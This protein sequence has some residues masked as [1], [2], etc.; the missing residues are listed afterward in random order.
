MNRYPTRYALLRDR[1]DWPDCTLDGLEADADGRLSRRRVPGL[2]GA[3]VDLPGPYQ[4]APSGVAVAGQFHAVADTGHDV[5]RLFDNSCAAEYVLGSGGPG[6]LAKLAAPAGLAIHGDQLWVADKGHDRLVCFS[7]ATRE[8]I[9]TIDDIA[10]PTSLAVD[11]GGRLHVIESGSGAVRRFDPW[12]AAAEGFD[13]AVL[14][15]AAAPGRIPGPFEPLFLALGSNGILHVS[16][17]SSGKILRFDA[18]GGWLEPFALP[19]GPAGALALADVLYAAD[20]TAGRLTMLDP[21]AG[22]LI[23]TVPGLHAPISGLAAGEAGVLVKTGPDAAI[24]TLTPQAARLPVGTVICG[25]IDAGEEQEWWRA[26]IDADTADGAVTL[27]VWQSDDAGLA[28][29]AWIPAPA[30]STLLAGLADPNLTSRRWIKVRATLHG[31]AGADGPTL[32]QVQLETPGEHY[33]DYL[34]MTYGKADTASGLLARL[35]AHTQDQLAG[36]EAQIDSIASLFAAD[37]APTGTLDWL[38]AWMAF[39]LPQSLN[40]AERRRLL[41]KIVALQDR[42]G[43]PASL[44]SLIELHTGVRPSLHEAFRDRRIWMLD[45][46]EGS[47]LGFDT[48][49][50]PV[51]PDGIIAADP[52]QAIEAGAG[53]RVPTIGSYIPGESVPQAAAMWGRGLFDDTAHLFCVTLPGSL[54]CEPEIAEAIMTLL[55]REKPAHTEYVLSAA[56]DGLRVGMGHRVG[57]ETIVAP[58][59]EPASLGDSLLDSGFVLG[60]SA[61][62]EHRFRPAASPH[63]SKATKHGASS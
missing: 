21:E 44:V 52:P 40:A 17:R 12:F 19:D 59:P 26:V 2:L 45:A 53:D 51:E 14:A 55:D 6:G 54:R 28:T 31:D 58:P 35:L 9:A 60:G 63:S 7:I 13:T 20:A 16:E 18:D 29:G 49:L 56:P 41:P 22:A 4:V 24:V 5:V 50:P 34:P 37:F 47:R 61:E 39:E 25:P 57:I 48:G 42:R 62:R 33:L 8:V 46:E 27:E 3:A 15:E 43:T 11:T 10:A 36:L 32:D 1:R 30:D 23:G 38:A